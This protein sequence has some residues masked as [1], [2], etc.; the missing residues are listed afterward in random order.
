MSQKTEQQ[1]GKRRSASSTAFNARDL[2]VVVDFR[3]ESH[4]A[5]PRAFDLAKKFGSKLTL[6]T[7]V[8]QNIVDII[9]ATSSLDWEAIRDEALAHYENELRKLATELC[10]QTFGSEMFERCLANI[11]YE[12]RWDK[13]FH[14]GLVEL[15]NNQHFD[16]IVK[17]AH[18]HN[19]LQKLFFTP[20]DWHLLRE[21]KTNILFVKKG[22]WPSSTSIMGAI[23]IEADDQ[24]QKLNQEIVETTVKLASLCQ[25]EAKILNVFPWPAIDLDKFK[26]LFDKKDQFLDIKNQHKN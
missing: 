4:Y 5:L 23:N 22:A 7:C 2:L 24:H 26:Y 20:T 21:T 8:Y 25:S 10:Q 11:H 12:V 18:H 16:L 19:T 15:I 17:T 9:P 1:K 13:S 6:A 3:Q 14:H